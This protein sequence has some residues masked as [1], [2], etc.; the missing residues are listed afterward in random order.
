MWLLSLLGL[1]MEALEL[2]VRLHAKPCRLCIP[3]MGR[4]LFPCLLRY[5]SPQ[6]CEG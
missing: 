4:H 5:D 2:A 1:R 6:N 3:G